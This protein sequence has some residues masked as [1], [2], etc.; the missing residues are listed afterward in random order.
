MALRQWDDRCAAAR[1][2]GRLCHDTQVSAE[3]AGNVAEHENWDEIMKFSQALRAGELVFCSGQVGI[4]ADGTTPTD[5]ARQYALAFDSLRAV[6]A[7]VGAAPEDVVDLTSF[8]IDYPQHMQ[9][10]I[11][12]KAAFH[13]DA[14]PAWTAIGVAK[15][16][17]P[18]ALVEVKAIAR[19]REA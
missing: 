19:I 1:G 4:D 18:G 9:E 3:G 7:D 13:G 2:D 6:L 14:R 16:G 8:H 12:A 11:A 17:T 15:L 10:F 5:P